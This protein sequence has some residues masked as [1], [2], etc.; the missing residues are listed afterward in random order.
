MSHQSG[1]KHGWV[2]TRRPRSYQPT[3][4]QEVFRDVLKVCGIEKGVPK[5]RLQQQM[6]ECIPEVYRRLKEGETIE[7][8]AEDLH[9][10]GM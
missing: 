6:R 3:K 8:I 5:A 1:G 7:R 2:V 4:Q 10:Q 9:S